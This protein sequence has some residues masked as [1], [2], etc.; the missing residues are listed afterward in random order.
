MSVRDIA[1][2]L[3]STLSEILIYDSDQSANREA[4]ETNINDHYEIY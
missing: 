4:I 3:Y 2:N 1:Y